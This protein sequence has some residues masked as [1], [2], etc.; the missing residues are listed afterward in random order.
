MDYRDCASSCVGLKG[1]WKVLD[2]LSSVPIGRYHET[3]DPAIW[4]DHTHLNQDLYKVPALRSAG[5]SFY[6]DSYDYVASSSLPC[7]CQT[8]TRADIEDINVCEG[9][10]DECGVCN[11]RAPST[12]WMLRHP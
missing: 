10:E 12:M 11:G 3:A 1:N 5:N 6:I 7:F 2:H 8:R 9:L 4:I